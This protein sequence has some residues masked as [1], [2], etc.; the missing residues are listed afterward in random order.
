[1]SLSSRIVGTGI[2]LTIAV[3]VGI[4]IGRLMEVRSLDLAVDAGVLRWSGKDYIIT[5]WQDAPEEKTVSPPEKS[6][7]GKEEVTPQTPIERYAE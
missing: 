1:M 6:S 3:A 7:R 2:I 4:L 5:E